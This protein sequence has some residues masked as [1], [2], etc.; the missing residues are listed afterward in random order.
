MT[1][2]LSQQSP[3]ANAFDTIRSASARRLVL[4]DTAI[5]SAEVLA[6]GVVPDTSVEMIAGDRDGVAQITEALQ[7]HLGTASLHLV[8]HGDPGA[9]YIGNTELSLETLNRYSDQLMSWAEWLAP[10]AELLIYGCEVAKDDRGQAFIAR[11]SEL[12]G[13]SIAASATKTGTATLGGDWHL[14]VKASESSTILA[15][16]PEAMMAYGSVLAAGD[17]DPTFGTGGKVSVKLGGQSAVVQPDGKVVVVGNTVNAGNVDFSVSRY[18]S[19]GS[20]DTTF[21]TDGKVATDFNGGSDLGYSVTLQSDGKIVVSGEADKNAFGT[22]D[23]AVGRYNSDG[24][25]DTSFGTN[26]KVTTDFNG[27][28]NVGFGSTLQSDGKVVVAGYARSA[29][30]TRNDFALSRYNIDGSLDTTFGTNGKVITEFGPTE[31]DITSS[32]GSKVTVQSDGK[33]LLTGSSGSVSGSNGADF[34]LSRYNSDGSL[35]TTFGTN[36]KVTTDFNGKDDSATKVIQQSDGKIVLAGKASNSSGDSDFALSRYNSDGSLD[37]TFGTNGKVTTDFNGRTDLVKSATLQSDGKIVVVGSANT[38]DPNSSP[39]NRFPTDRIDY[40]VSRYNSDG[41]LDTTFGAN[42]KVITDF[43]GGNTAADSAYAVS[44]QP[45][46]NILVVGDNGFARYLGDP[47]KKTVKNDFN[48]D[49]KTDIVVRNQATGDNAIAFMDD[50]VVSQFVFST[51]VADLNWTI[52][53]AGDFDKDGKPDVV[54]RNGK[55]GQNA[56]ALMDGTTLREIVSPEILPDPN[57]GIGGTGDFNNDGNLDILYRNKATGANS[58]ALMSG[59]NLSQL[60]STDILPG[61]DWEIGGAGDFNSDG[62]DDI[63]FRN[64]ATGENSFALMNGTELGQIV[65]T[66]ILPDPNWRVGS[67]GDYNRDGKA[68]ILYRNQAT[69]QDTIALMNGTSLSQLSPTLTVADTNWQIGA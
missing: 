69:G 67:V 14:E 30:G 48:G 53:G 18:N 35:D 6:A 63:L 11:L 54:L 50:T 52:D 1:I 7:R 12:T 64:T 5:T 13:A 44:V 34:A 68:D 33:I 57:W 43:T 38:A 39:I 27:S 9:I 21:G 15:F 4:I 41:S 56:I 25:L 29:T 47:I 58:I 10:G 2:N 31:S 46:G 40:A 28:D 61:L 22:K 36:G 59:T 49:G 20:L 55:T 37:T 24:S 60:V 65:K 62:K 23:F 66:E 3:R 17:L 42:G 16:Q 45:D 8:S 19:D 32:N 26:G 51:P